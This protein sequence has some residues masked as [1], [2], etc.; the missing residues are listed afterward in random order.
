M[1]G[2]PRVRKEAGRCRSDRVPFVVVVN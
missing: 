1:Q 2:R